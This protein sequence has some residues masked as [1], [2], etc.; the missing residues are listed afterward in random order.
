MSSRV[1]ANAS[2][3]FDFERSNHEPNVSVQSPGPRVRPFEA[4]QEATFTGKSP[5][6]CDRPFEG[7][8]QERGAEG[9]V[10]K[11]NVEF[12]HYVKRYVK[13][14]KI[15]F[16]RSPKLISAVKECLKT[17]FKADSLTRQQKLYAENF[18]IKVP[19]WYKKA[20]SDK[21]L[22]RLHEGMY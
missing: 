22:F 9:D 10:K 7:N 12:Y 18:A 3:S 6:P 5:V 2:T 14:N 20:K 17:W 15:P 21:Q 11:T 13:L 19:Y 8:E 16:Q 4:D 1:L